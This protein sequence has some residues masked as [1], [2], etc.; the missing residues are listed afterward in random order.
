MVL[1]VRKSRS[2]LTKEDWQVYQATGFV[3]HLLAIFV[4]HIGM[5]RLFFA[6][7]NEFVRKFSSKLFQL[8]PRPNAQ[9][10]LGIVGWSNFYL[11]F[12]SG[13]DISAQRAWVS[14]LIIHFCTVFRK[15]PNICTRGVF[16]L[17]TKFEF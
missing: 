17:H 3:A 9:F 16:V 8:V 7:I 14:V 10:I 2:Q 15:G 4:L 6:L 1:E 12:L 13:F 5:A 11:K